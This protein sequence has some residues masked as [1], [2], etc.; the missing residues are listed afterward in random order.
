VVGV[1]WEDELCIRQHLVSHLH[2]DIYVWIMIHEMELLSLYIY[3]DIEIG[4]AIFT[5]DAA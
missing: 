2:A 5:F 3:V 1:V 4:M